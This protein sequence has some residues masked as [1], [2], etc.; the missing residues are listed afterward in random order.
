MQKTNLVLSRCNVPKLSGTGIDNKNNNFKLQRLS[1]KLKTAITKQRKVVGSSSS[2]NYPIQEYLRKT[3]FA[4]F[5]AKI[6]LSY[7]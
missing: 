5:V 4:G 7:L 1:Y 3:S 2:S 6:D